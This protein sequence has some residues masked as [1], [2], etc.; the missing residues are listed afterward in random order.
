MHVHLLV[1]LRSLF[2][3][4]WDM[5]CWTLIFQVRDCIFKVIKNATQ[6]YFW[7][8]HINGTPRYQ[9]VFINQY[10]PH[11][12]EYPIYNCI[13][14]IFYCAIKCHGSSEKEWVWKIHLDTTIYLVVQY[15]RAAYFLWKLTIVYNLV[16][17]CDQYFFPSITIFNKFNSQC[18]T[19]WCA[20]M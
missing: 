16:K 18:C 19:I 9:S 17:I 12:K 13:W 2:Y 8:N 1:L 11:L 10:G 15:S 4:P 5:R 14:V 3:L 7:S 20:L 6:S